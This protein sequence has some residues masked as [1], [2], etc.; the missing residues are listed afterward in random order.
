MHK[1]IDKG[2]NS[3]TV[4]DLNKQHGDFKILVDLVYPPTNFERQK[5]GTKMNYNAQNKQ[6]FGVENNKLIEE[7]IL[8]SIEISSC[9]SRNTLVSNPS[10]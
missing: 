5:K 9:S 8:A 4:K 2:S 10:C 6:M 3:P 7:I 1:T